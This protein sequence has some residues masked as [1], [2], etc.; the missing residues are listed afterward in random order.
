MEV[1]KDTGRRRGVL[2]T[3]WPSGGDEGGRKSPEL[4]VSTVLAWYKLSASP[5]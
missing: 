3:L 4:T 5:L 2:F 1:R